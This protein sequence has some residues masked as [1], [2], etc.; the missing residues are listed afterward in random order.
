MIKKQPLLD[1]AYRVYSDGNYNRYVF[2][3]PYRID[4]NDLPPYEKA[5]VEMFDVLLFK[6]KKHIKRIQGIAELPAWILNT[7]QFNFVQFFKDL[8]QQ[9]FSLAAAAT[10]ISA[11]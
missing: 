8:F 4:I 3:S 2:K 6:S 1:K 10:E 7:K 5:I 11:L 9:K